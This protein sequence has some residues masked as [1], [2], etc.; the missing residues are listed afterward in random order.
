[1]TRS[2]L[3]KLLIVILIVTSLG[4]FL[5]TGFSDRV[6][7]RQITQKIE[8]STSP[9]SIK[10][11][12][13]SAYHDEKLIAKIAADELKVKQRKFLVFNIRPFHEAILTNARLEFHHYDDTPSEADLISSAREI[14]SID[15]D[16]KALS[17]EMGLITRGVIKGLVFKMYKAES[18]YLL[19]KAKKAYMDFRNGTISM[20]S[21]VLDEVTTGRTVESG[22]VI[23]N[24]KEKVFTVPGKYLV[25]GPE[26]MK[27]GKGMRIDINATAK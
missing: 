16:G 17:K 1:M 10:G 26:G 14:L 20:K 9:F 3:I 25:N 15:S 11:F 24:N 18:P 2:L 7:S 8:Q 22:S 12:S 13:H 19:V 5:W 6:P 27:S 4:F 21:V 23:W